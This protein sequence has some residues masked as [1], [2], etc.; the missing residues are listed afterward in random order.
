MRWSTG[1]LDALHGHLFAWVPVCLGL[2]ISVYFG[3]MQEPGLLAYLW[4]GAAALALLIL[5]RLGPIGLRP[6][7][8]GAALIALG[9]LLAGA[10]A[11][12][13]AAPVLGFRYYGPVEGRIVLIDR[14]S[15]DQQR[16]T[17]DQV[18]LE[19]MDPARTPARVR[20]TVG[21]RQ[22]H[23]D[24][25]PGQ[26][27][28][29]TA[30]L[31]PPEGAVE[32]GGFDFQRLAWFQRLGAVGFSRSPVMALAPPGSG[33]GS[34]FFARLRQS[35]SDGVQAA[36]PDDAGGFVTAV[37]TN[38]TSGL[39]PAALD[40]LR[41]S[42][43]AHILSISGLHM[44]LLAAFVFAALRS[45]AALVPYVALRVSSK[46]IAAL[47][48]LAAAGF[49]Y[50]LS[51]GAVA[52]QRSFI[53][54]AVMLVAVLVDRRAIS[55][56]T[57]AIAAL[58]VLAVQPES[59]LQAGFQMS[60]AATIGLVAA[61]GA[62]RDRPDWRLPRV[63]RPVAAVALA[64]LVAGAATAPYGAAAF[65]KLSGYGLLANMAAEPVMAFLVMPGVVI[66]AVLSLVGLEGPVLWLMVQGARWILWV[67][68]R[69]A[70]LDGAVIGVAAPPALALPLLT[71]GAL[72][73]VLIPSMVRWA[74]ILP[75][76]AAVAF[77][78]M[79]DRPMVLISA[80]GALVGVM[81]AD[82]RALNRA[83]GE[84][85]TAQTWL[86][87]DGDL[88]GQRAAAARVGLVPGALAMQF[89]L[90]AVP[91]RI[92]EGEQ[93][94][95]ALVALCQ[96]GGLLILTEALANG[97]LDEPPCTIIDR[98][99]LAQRGA[100]ALVLRDG[101]LA[102]TGARDWSGQRLWTQEPARVESTDSAGAVAKAGSAPG[103]PVVPRP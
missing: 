28:M 79:A 86:E 35:I 46:K 95:G 60:F 41:A 76:V 34:L 77:W 8:I 47:V 17:L 18:V 25:A 5:A 103:L 99:V 38:D 1:P 82:G 33:F 44:S 101:R 3:L 100:L 89:D 36:F 16:L 30:F 55:L 85:F 37:L 80:N 78:A 63:L 102:M 49:Y 6:P 51:G 13:V 66:A 52:T 4:A 62:L 21:D 15:S 91:L 50:G 54:I 84:K 57:V 98:E 12:T 11:Q 14:S 93:S 71:L 40:S 20:L 92:V 53:M 29:L 2:G 58:I 96:P 56:R 10:R 83:K 67:S 48:A 32:P 94:T 64:S 45:L 90:G 22:T 19:R 59:L 88:A 87:N 97:R 42:S 26:R 61:F 69:I 81:T 65:N 7:A 68:D 31:A 73:L 23:I 24:F 43:L 74:A 70:G 27:V 39:S 75:I 72:W 9:F